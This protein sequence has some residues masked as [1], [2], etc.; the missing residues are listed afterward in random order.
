MVKERLDPEVA[1]AIRAAKRTIEDVARGDGNEA[2]TRRRVERIFESVM[3]Y[4]IEH[5]SREHAVKGSGTTEHV[6]FVVQIE[7][8]PDAAPIVMVE[9]KRVG[10]DLRPKHLRQVSSYAINAGCEWVLLTNGREWRVYH[11]E[12]GQPPITKLVEQWNLLKDDTRVL[13]QKFGLLNF[14][15]V[16]RGSLKKLWERTQVLAPKSILAALLS[17]ESLK[18]CRR[19]LRKN[20]GVLVDCGDFV[21][22]VKRL[23]NET[24]AKELEGINLIIPERRKPGRKL[25]SKKEALLEPENMPPQPPGPTAAQERSETAPG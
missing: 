6:D 13:A 22:G 9:L 2:E 4:A 15:S 17:P 16:R 19:A 25:K 10:V 8:G 12:F 23:L 7:K 5:L 11:V 21:Q 24:A 14:K 3:G 1:R 20:T 18:A